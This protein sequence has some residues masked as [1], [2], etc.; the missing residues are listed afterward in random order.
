MGITETKKLINFFKED[1]IG[2]FQ[3][4]YALVGKELGELDSEE[5]KD[6]LIEIG[7]AVIE[8]L[9]NM[10]IT[11]TSLAFGMVKKLAAKV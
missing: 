1:V 9:A 5:K 2:L 8:I 10:K 3:I 11:P 7:S 6:L 4:D